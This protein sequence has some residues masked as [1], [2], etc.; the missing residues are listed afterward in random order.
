MEPSES[1]FAIF[2]LNAKEILVLGVLLLVLGVVAGIAV[3]QQPDPS[4]PAVRHGDA[5]PARVYINRAD[6]ATLT[7]LPGIGKAKARKI[8]ESRKVTP[9]RNAD[10]LRQA[11]GGIP[12]D[13][14][15]KA[16]RYIDYSQ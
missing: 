8:I 15:S 7:A 16:V 6:E 1:G 2:R 11:A 9:I 14:L 12:E 5:P 3:F 4:P 13:D 10:D